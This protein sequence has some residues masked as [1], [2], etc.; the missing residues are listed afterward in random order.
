MQI[1]RDLYAPMR[2][3][4]RLAA[5]A[6]LPDGP[7]PWPVV[8]ERT[9]YGNSL[10]SRSEIDGSGRLIDREEMAAAFVEHGMAVVY[11]DCRGRHGSEGEF[12]KYVNEAEDGFD[13]LVWLVEQDFCNGDI[14]MQGLS[15]AAHTQ[16][17]AA[18]L[19]PP[20]LRTMVLDSGGFDNAYRWGIRQGGAF[21]LK[22]ATWAFKQ[23][24]VLAGGASE[25]LRA[26][27]REWFGR[28]PWSE[29]NSPL[30]DFPEYE[31][32][33]LRQWREGAFGDYWDVPGLHN[34]ALYDAMPAIPVLFMSSWFDVYVPSTLRNYQA[35]VDKGAQPSLI[36]GPWLHGDR[37]VPTAGDMDF[38]A[39][40]VF[41]T[42]FGHGWLEHRVAWMRVVLVE[43]VAP[44]PSVRL[45]EMGANRWVDHSSWPLA[46]ATPL[47]MYPDSSGSL[48]EPRDG[49]VVLLADPSRPVPMV[50]GQATSG[51]PVFVGGS[52]DQVEDSRFFGADGSSRPLSER[53][54]VLSFVSDVLEED[55]VVAGPVFVDVHFAAQTRDFDVAAKLIDVHPDGSAWNITDGIQ[56]A[57]YR[58]S[59]SAP[60]LVEPGVEDHLVVELPATY[61]RFRAGHRIRI[62]LA[63]SNFPHFDVNPNSGEPEGWAE[64]P[65]VAR[66]RILLGEGK[67][68]VR[69]QVVQCEA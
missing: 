69:L 54:D 30:A 32:Y 15:Y 10:Q 7:G 12:E 46:D 68:A 58:R 66:T 4:V 63:G 16:L 17:A 38:G 3:G 23:S 28:M 61:N 40:A 45:F 31:A 62:D 64:H 41:D 42:G 50:G 19:N 21:D 20:G 55:L 34:A 14:G 39:D 53:D 26:E 59:F 43:G 37:V 1:L 57:R 5:D 49:E 35:F 18:G 51:K 13:T 36:M 65:E 52:F 67:T 27:I 9:P 56:R 22:Q 8:L 60:E 29:G 44:E 24:K 25:D 33:V 11:Q 47:T 48:G 2:D 6:Y